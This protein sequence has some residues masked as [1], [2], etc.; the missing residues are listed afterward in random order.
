[1][2]GRPQQR[3]H[4]RI[5]ALFDKNPKLSREDLGP[6]IHAISDETHHETEALLTEQ[7]AKATQEHMRSREESRLRCTTAQASHRAVAPC[8]AQESD[9]EALE[10]LGRRLFCGECH[11]QDRRWV[12]VLPAAIKD[13]ARAFPAGALFL[14]PDSRLTPRF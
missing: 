5:Q 4:D 2:R 6:Q 7:L 1:L 10:T 13:E 9:P 3:R 11:S 8:A 14:D 12:A